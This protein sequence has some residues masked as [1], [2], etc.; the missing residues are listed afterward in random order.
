MWRLSKFWRG[1]R[2]EVPWVDRSPADIVRDQV[3]LTIQ[4]FDA[5]A[6]AET[7]ERTIDHLR[8]DA[9]LLHASDYPHWQFDGDKAL[10]PGLP[11]SLRRK[12]MVDNPLATY[13]RLRE[14]A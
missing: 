6:S 5:P 10:P 11:E 3:R 13:D 12:I 14:N 4:P 1:V 2:A 7:V 9:I 8:S